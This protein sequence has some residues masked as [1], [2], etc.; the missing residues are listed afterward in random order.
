M[1]EK[2]YLLNIYYARQPSTNFKKLNRK[3]HK[4]GRKPIVHM[5]KLIPNTFKY[6]F[7]GYKVAEPS[8]WDS[9]GYML[10]F[11][12]LYSSKVVH[13]NSLRFEEFTFFNKVVQD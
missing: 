12:P 5:R 13:R 1:L 9:R 2:E 3:Q 7:Q 6:I 10:S 8:Q 4:A 11:Y